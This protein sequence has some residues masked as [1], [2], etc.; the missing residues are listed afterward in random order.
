MGGLGR[1]RL[2]RRTANVSLLGRLSH[3]G[4]TNAWSKRLAG[5][6]GIE[7][8]PPDTN[9]DS[10]TDT[11]AIANRAANTD[12]DRYGHSDK[13]PTTYCNVHRD[14]HTQPDLDSSR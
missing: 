13:Q 8:G 1:P 3:R 10:D 6:D 2:G 7:A 5:R 9:T 12:V 4:C 11:H 14:L